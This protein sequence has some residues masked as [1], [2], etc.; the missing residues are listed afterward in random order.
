M[1]LVA[2]LPATMTV[3]Y[4]QELA[5]AVG[6]LT[7]A[8]VEVLLDDGSSKVVRAPTSSTA[9]TW[10]SDPKGLTI[11]ERSRFYAVNLLGSSIAAMGPLESSMLLVLIEAAHVFDGSKLLFAALQ[12]FPA[13][14]GQSGQVR[15]VYAALR[16]KLKATHYPLTSE[17]GQYGLAYY[18]RSSPWDRMPRK[19]GLE[20]VPGES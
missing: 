9:R 8:R 18:A 1:R 11:D 5:R 10:L 16:K 7:G 14:K 13:W 17:R 20:V 12:Q 4:A 3:A 15:Q 2:H 6:L 19:V